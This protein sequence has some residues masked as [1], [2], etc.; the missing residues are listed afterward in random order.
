MD[1]NHAHQHGAAPG[2]RRAL[3]VVMVSGLPLTLT[4]CEVLDSLPPWVNA[5]LLQTLIAA[6][7]IVALLIAIY[8]GYEDSH[9]GGGGG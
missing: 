1:R 4:G 6:V 8:K 2:I 7:I 9:W 3:V 5:H